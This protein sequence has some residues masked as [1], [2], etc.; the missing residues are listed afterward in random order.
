MDHGEQDH[1]RCEE[2]R[3][4]DRDIRLQR[5]KLVADDRRERSKLDGLRAVYAELH[6]K[7]VQLQSARAAATLGS[8]IPGA[9]GGTAGTAAL[10]FS[11]DIANIEPKVQDTKIKIAISEEK[12][13][14]F[15][16]NH[17]RLNRI[18]A[19]NADIMR[20]LNCAFP[21]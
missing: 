10:N 14:G 20:S 17:D 12:I 5:A 6:A 7:L 16:Q 4:N 1:T 21:S 3:K 19:E 11:I 2:L 8:A 13:A 18:Q 15:Q 9:A